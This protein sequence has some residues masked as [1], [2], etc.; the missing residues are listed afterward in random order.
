MTA[1]LTGLN[2]VCEFISADGQIVPLTRLQGTTGLFMPPFSLASE[3]VPLEGGSR[4]R[5][6]NTEANKIVVPACIKGDTHLDYRTQMRNIASALNPLRGAGRLRFYLG[7]TAREV[8]CYY[9]GGLDH[10]E[11]YPTF[12][13]PRIEFTALDP[14]WYDIR[15]RTYRFSLSGLK[16]GWFP[17]LPIRLN[18]NSVTNK[19]AAVNPG[20]VDAWP[21]WTLRGSSAGTL[22]I[23]NLTTN[24]RLGLTHANP[25]NGTVVIDTR[26]GRKSVTYN[27]TA[28]LFSKLSRLSMWPLVPGDN[29][30]ELQIPGADDTT[31]MSLAFR[32][33][34]LSV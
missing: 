25:P 6:T 34:Y 17:T 3:P 5:A 19:V 14:Y 28:N 21:I 8:N 29:R 18:V 23:V 24:K 13:L 27:G 30:I 9:T 4:F 2:P 1:E 31:V 12:G 33:R 10:P 16:N 7:D 26:P 15:D 32:G 20:D 11:E 22:V